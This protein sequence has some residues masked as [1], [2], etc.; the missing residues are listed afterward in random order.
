MHGDEVLRSCI[1]F[2]RLKKQDLSAGITHVQNDCVE[3]T[4]KDM[5]KGLTCMCNTEDLCNDGRTAKGGLAIIASLILTLF[6]LMYWT[7]FKTVSPMLSFKIFHLDFHFFIFINDLSV[8][9]ENSCRNDVFFKNC[10]IL[11][12]KLR[13]RENKA[14]KW[15]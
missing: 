15:I 13:K 6:S 1:D 3:H 8:I 7:V 4:L 12:I 11:W 9:Y 2:E 5:K 14:W 10:E